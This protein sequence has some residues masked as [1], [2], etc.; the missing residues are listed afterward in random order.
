M[1]DRRYEIPKGTRSSMC[2]GCRKTIFWIP[3]STGKMMPVD[4]DGIS[5]FATC[6][7]ARQF[8]REVSGLDKEVR[9]KSKE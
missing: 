6:P 9:E 2:K 7:K 8:R 4:S 3:T 1:N 5:H